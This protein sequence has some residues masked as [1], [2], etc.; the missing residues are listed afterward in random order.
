MITGQLVDSGGR[1]RYRLNGI[2]VDT[3][4]HESSTRLDVRDDRYSRDLSAALQKA[5]PQVRTASYSAGGSSAPRT[6]G[7]FLDRGIM[8]ASRGGI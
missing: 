1:Y 8:F 4:A 7:A 2:N 6:T 5:A 3:A